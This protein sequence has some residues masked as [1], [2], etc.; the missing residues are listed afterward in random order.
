MPDPVAIAALLR[1]LLGRRLLAVTEARHWYDERPVTGTTGLLHFWL[2]FE[3][4]P[5]IMAHGCGDLLKLTEEEPYSSYD[6]QENGRTVVGPVQPTDLLNEVVGQCLV[7][8]GL[9]QG[10]STIPAVGG[11]LLRFE[12]NELLVATLADEWIC[13]P[14]L[15]PAELRQY[16]SLIGWLSSPAPAAEGQ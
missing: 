2:H 10:Y 15:I 11:I 16:L 7:D 1:P 13:Q 14:G 6:M 3:G 4:V 12:R 5:A 9:A 8:V